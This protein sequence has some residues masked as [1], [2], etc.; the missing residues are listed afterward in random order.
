MKQ[1]QKRKNA[2]YHFG[3]KKNVYFAVLSTY[4]EKT[5]ETRLELMKQ[6]AERPL[7][8]ERVRALIEAYISPHIRLIIDDGD[9]AYGRLI[10]IEVNKVRLQFR[11]YLRECYPDVSDDIL[12]RGIGLIVATMAQAPFDPSYRTLTNKSPLNQSSG[13]LIHIALSFAFGGIKEL[14]RDPIS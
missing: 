2:N 10:S 14:F 8:D 1:N 7:G 12:S 13:D 4:F 9:H 11:K 6:A 3:S 5:R